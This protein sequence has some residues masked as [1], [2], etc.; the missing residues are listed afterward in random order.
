[1]EKVIE[2]LYGPQS[3]TFQIVDMV[4]AGVDR[5]LKQFLPNP[6]GPGYTVPFGRGGDYKFHNSPD[7]KAVADEGLTTSGRQPPADPA[8]TKEWPF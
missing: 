2:D 3:F 7:P 1:M 5:A 4:K 6:G 8:E